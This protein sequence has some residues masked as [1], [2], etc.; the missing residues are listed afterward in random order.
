M[1]P[2][3][4]THVERLQLIN[5]FRILEKLDPENAEVYASSRKIIA[6]GYTIQYADVFSEVREETTTAECSYVHNVLSMYSLLI[7]SFESLTDKEGLTEEDVRFQG[8]DAIHEGKHYY[9]AA[10]LKQEGKWQ[11]LLKGGLNSHSERPMRLYPRMLAN[12]EPIQQQV[13]AAHYKSWTPSS[14]PS[15]TG[16]LTA[17]QIKQI[18]S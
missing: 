9:F 6:N 2:T 5:Q 12:F 15:K 7:D 10:H 8:F 14:D 11:K 17:D 4:L 1:E 3:T 18:I 16:I 13:L